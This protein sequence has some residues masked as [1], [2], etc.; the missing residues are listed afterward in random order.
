M[1]FVKNLV[2]FAVFII[3]GTSA[4]QATSS[5]TEAMATKAAVVGK[6]ACCLNQEVPANSEDDLLKAVSMLQVS[7]GIE[8]AEQEFNSK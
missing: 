7:I 2:V 6:S 4:S 3:L 8:A 1:A 5:C